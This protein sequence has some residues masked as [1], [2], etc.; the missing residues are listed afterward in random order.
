MNRMTLGILALVGLLGGGVA[1]ATLES[2]LGG[3]AY[4]DT[5]TDLTW[6]G[7]M[8]PNGK[9][10]LFT[11]LDFASNFALEGVG[12]WRIPT[13]FELRSI[14]L[15]SFT[16]LVIDFPFN[17]NIWYPSGP[18]DVTGVRSGWFWYSDFIGGYALNG[19]QYS[20][21]SPDSFEGY[22][23]SIN[24]NITLAEFD[25]WPVHSGDVLA[26]PVPEP[27]VWAMMLAGIGMWVG[28]YLSVAYRAGCNRVTGPMC[29]VCN[30]LLRRAGDVI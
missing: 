14:V 27:G 5:E 10:N 9:A 18:F 16:N 25:L 21:F 7:S 12:D 19:L 11:Q 15:H 17:S 23:G 3:L 30:Y 13:F 2:R 6:T 1:H 24:D 26:S 4:Y 22:A 29:G 20:V 8:S 28:V